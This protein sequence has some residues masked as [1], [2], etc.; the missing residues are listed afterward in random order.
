MKR[1][2][3]QIILDTLVRQG[4]DVVF[5]YPGGACLPLYDALYD[6]QDKIRHVLVRHEQGAAFAADGFARASGKAGVCIVTSGPGV[7]NLTTGIASAYMD[8]V[9]VIAITGQVSR[10]LLG[11]DG[12]QETD[13]TGIMLPITKHN[14]LVLHAK[15]LPRVMAEAYYIATT[16]RPGPVHIDVPKDVFLET[17]EFDDYPSEVNIPGYKPKKEPG[18]PALIKEAIE[19]IK[20]SRKPVILAGHGVHISGAYAELREFA[21]KAHIPVITTLHGV[22][23]F[24]ESHELSFGMV[25]M[26]GNL[27]AN[28]AVDRAD[29]IIGIGMRFDDRVTGRLADFAKSAKV[30]HIDIDPAEIGKNVK[31]TVGIVGDV[32]CT[33]AELNK[34]LQE[35]LDHGEWYHQ[36]CKWREEHPSLYIRET[37]K[38]LAQ[39]VIRQ[40]YHTTKGEATIVAD[41]GQAQMWAAQHFWYDRPN[42]FFSSGGLGAMGYA[43]PAAIGV[44]FARPNEQVWSI[45]GDGGFQI[46]LQDL[47]V[48]VQDDVDI[49]VAIINNGHLGMIRQWQTLFYKERFMA[50][51]LVNPDF[52]KLAEAYGVPGFRATTKQEVQ[53]ALSKAAKMKGPVVLDLVVEET[54]MVY[55][56]VPPGA[57]LAETVEAAEAVAR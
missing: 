53:E 30:I 14:W 40:I 57:S 33:L 15:D 18:D 9:P 56:M 25:G 19:V 20:A 43:F 47:A 44:K 51:R 38:V 27:Y 36:I 8:S 48:L 10:N 13:A 5:G 45:I 24:P 37:D 31:P 46:T 3:A 17:V 11:T 29:L 21:E 4:T 1:T 26:H 34:L 42:T 2:G 32:R 35:P 41:V 12:F 55:P 54:E 22:S 49:K 16:G 52:V 6:Y 50:A 28:W 39:W 23:S 7:T